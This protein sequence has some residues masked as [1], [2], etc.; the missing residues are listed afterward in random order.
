MKDHG[1]IDRR[2]LVARYLADQLSEEERRE[3]E[4]ALAQSPDLVEDLEATARL[5]VGLAHLQEKGQLQPLLARR[6]KPR[7]AVLAL[8][9]SIAGLAVIVA[10]WFGSRSTPTPLM[11]G[12]VAMLAQRSGAAPAVSEIRSILRTRS[13]LPGE[14]DAELTAAP[15]SPT[16]VELRIRPEFRPEP[17]VYRASLLKLRDDDTERELVAVRGLPLHAQ[18]HVT[19]FVDTGRVSAGRYRLRLSADGDAASGP[20]STFLL[21]VRPAD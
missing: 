3:F 21:V 17:P 20:S 8:A 14:Y 15:A 2:H 6:E 10:L 5:K 16:V 13:G 4:E 11:A 1:D 18:G 19:V 9:A 12:T 7:G